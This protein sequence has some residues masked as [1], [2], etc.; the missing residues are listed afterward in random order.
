MARSKNFNTKQLL[1]ETNPSNLKNLVLGSFLAVFVF[2]GAFLV[3]DTATY[4]ATENSSL[5]ASVITF[6]L[7]DYLCFDSSI[8]N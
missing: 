6:S 5:T 4:L 3:A 2:A 8:C 7:G 1:G